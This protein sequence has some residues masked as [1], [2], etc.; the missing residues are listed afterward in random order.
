MTMIGKLTKLFQKG[1]SS[2]PRL[3]LAAF[4]KHPGWDDHIDD[5]GLDTT[6]LV[7]VKS[8]LYT[9]GISSNIDSADWDH[10][11]EDQRLPRFAHEFVW[12]WAGETVVGILWASQ[13]GKGRSKYPMA[14][15]LQGTGVP[16]S[17]LCSVGLERLRTLRDRCKGVTT[18]G[19]VRVAVEQARSELLEASRGVPE[20]DNE[21][22][23]HLI[24]RLRSGSTA[25]SDDGF[26]RILYDIERR[27]GPMREGAGKPRTRVIDT[28]AHQFRLP[29]AT[30]G[31]VLES[32][33]AWMAVVM[34]AIGAG[35]VLAAG[36]LAVDATEAGHVDLVVGEPTPASLFCLRATPAREPMTSDIPFNMEE[37]FVSSARA[38]MLAWG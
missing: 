7:R 36:V 11:T 10:L 30:N 20:G 38:R 14:L 6:R 24:R 21:P 33:R 22:E 34:D 16:V 28:S 2:A 35:P 37:G 18:A 9:Q 15:C 12:R 13:D 31:T 17:W 27:L 32:A 4:G 29:K 25:V 1:P 3:A 19:S 26:V 5:L 8:V 23:R